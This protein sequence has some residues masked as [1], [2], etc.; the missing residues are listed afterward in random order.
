[1]NE[2]REI[3]AVLNGG[4]TPVAALELSTCEANVKMVLNMNITDVM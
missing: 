1:M 3:Q 2:P 4:L